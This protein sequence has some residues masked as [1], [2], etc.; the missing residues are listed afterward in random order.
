MKRPLIFASAAKPAEQ[1][2]TD[3]RVLQFKPRDAS[4]PLNYRMEKKSDSAAEIYL[5]DSVGGFFGVTAKQFAK[6]LK[7]LGSVKTIDL[8]VNSDGGDVFDGRAIYTQLAQHPAR[9]VARVDGIAASIASLICMAADEIRMADGA[10]MMIHNAWGVSIGNSAEM[11]RMAD[12]LDS[13][14]TTIQET[15][16]ART[17]NSVADIK[18]WM[19]EE[20]WMPAQDA[21]DKGFADIK[22]EPVQVA[23]CIHDPSRFKH[24]PQAILPR[25]AAAMTK[26]AALKR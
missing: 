12:L 6:D 13:V 10:F 2:G 7:A 20:T 19:D 9:I 22:D 25:R 5:Y 24:V 18:G 3:P 8:R 23:A 14:D 26:I 16:A 17:K 15:Y 4:R 21:V 11:R 1:T